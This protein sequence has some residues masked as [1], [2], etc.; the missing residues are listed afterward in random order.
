MFQRA[1]AVSDPRPEI[2][3]TG[4][5]DGRITAQYGDNCFHK[6]KIYGWL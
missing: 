4:V 3:R 1:A 2:M 6:R 5:A